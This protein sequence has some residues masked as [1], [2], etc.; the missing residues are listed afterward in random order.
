MNDIKQ[1]NITYHLPSINLQHCGRRDYAVNSAKSRNEFDQF[2]REHLYWQQKNLFVKQP[3]IHSNTVLRLPLDW[4][5]AFETKELSPAQTLPL[6]PYAP[7]LV[8]LY[9]PITLCLCELF[10]DL[11]SLDKL[12]VIGDHSWREEHKCLWQYSYKAFYMC[13]VWRFF[14]NWMKKSY[15]YIYI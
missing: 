2:G 1:K 6:G 8:S 10:T 4:L 13:T 7:W 14:R 11:C 12:C 15:I 3:S 9:S 5:W